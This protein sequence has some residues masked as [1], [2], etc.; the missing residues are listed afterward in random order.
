MVRSSVAAFKY[1]YK[2]RDGTM[3]DSMPTMNV[4]VRKVSQAVGRVGGEMTSNA[5]AVSHYTSSSICSLYL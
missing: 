5:D 3:E 4:E 2:T 1:R